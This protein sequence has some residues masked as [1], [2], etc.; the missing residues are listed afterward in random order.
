MYLDNRGAIDRA[1]HYSWSLYND[2][3]FKGNLG[4]CIVVIIMII[5]DLNVYNACITGSNP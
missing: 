1:A 4:F 3:R 2:C 5:I